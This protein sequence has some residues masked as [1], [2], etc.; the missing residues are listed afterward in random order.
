M[1]GVMAFGP[2][3]LRQFRRQ[4]HIDQERYRL[5]SIVSSSERLAA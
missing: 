4:R 2:Q 1:H 5:N 3:P